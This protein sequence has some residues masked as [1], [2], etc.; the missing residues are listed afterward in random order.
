[1]DTS[2]TTD[3]QQAQREQPGSRS[4]YDKARDSP[5]RAARPRTL[6]S[7]PGVDPDIADIR[8]RP[9]LA[10]CRSKKKSKRNRLHD[11]QQ[12]GLSY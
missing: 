4:A 8:P 2:F 3:D 7:A 12:A 6:G 1:M 11:D 10:D 9:Q 5:D